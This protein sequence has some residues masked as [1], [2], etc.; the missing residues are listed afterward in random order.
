MGWIRAWRLEKIIGQ[1]GNQTQK[2]QGTSQTKM[3]G[4]SG[5]GFKRA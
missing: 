5:Q 3:E 2:D 1:N 4:L